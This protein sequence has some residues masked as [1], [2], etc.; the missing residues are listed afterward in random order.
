MTDYHYSGHYAPEILKGSERTAEQLEGHMVEVYQF[1]NLH[2]RPWDSD[3]LQP[4]GMLQLVYA[5]DFGELAAEMNI[6]DH[7]LG[8]KTEQDK[9]I[10]PERFQMMRDYLC[11]YIERQGREIRYGF[12]VRR[13]AVSLERP[14]EYRITQ[15]KSVDNQQVDQRRLKIITLARRIENSLELAGSF[16]LYRYAVHKVSPVMN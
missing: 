2:W 11:Y 12:D 15:Y 8:K 16:R 7:V 4:A 14:L 3:F 9:L 10:L 6:R 13:N 5:V 1:G